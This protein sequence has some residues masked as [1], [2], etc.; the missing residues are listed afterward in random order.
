MRARA[1][2]RRTSPSAAAARPRM[3]ISRPPADS[4]CARWSTRSRRARS[5]TSPASCTSA[6]ADRCSGPALL[7]D[8]LGRRVVDAQRPLPVEHRRRRVRRCG[9]AARSRDD[10]GRGRVEDLHDA[11]DADEPRRRA[12]VAARCRRRRPGRA[13]DRRYRKARGGGRAG[14]RRNARPPV[15]R[16]CR[17]A[18]FAVE[19]GRADAPRWRSAGM[20]SRR[21]SKARP[22]WT[23][24]SASPSRAQNVPLIAA[25]ADR[26]YV[27]QLRLPDARAV[28]L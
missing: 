16:R 17:R 8:A 21:C 13:V 5:A 25:F 24:T 2:R 12:R 3:S 18:L 6:S 26:L 19:L 9:Q 10:A 1:G 27:E 28:R 15:R 14:H 11:R 22:R 20:R 7:V 4:A 23:A